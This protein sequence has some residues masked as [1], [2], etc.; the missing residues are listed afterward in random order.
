MIFFVRLTAMVVPTAATIFSQTGAS[1][2]AT[3]C[4]SSTAR[5]MAIRS[6]FA[7]WGISSRLCER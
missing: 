2:R 3:L 6:R 5:P 1:P 7:F 4:G